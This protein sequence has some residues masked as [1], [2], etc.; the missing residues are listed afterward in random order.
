MKSVTLEAFPRSV[1]KRNAVKKLRNGGRIPGV[2]YGRGLG[3][4]DVEIDTNA[5]E[6]LVK[7][8]TSEALLVDLNCD[9]KKNLALIQEAQQH[10]LSG[11]FLHIDL[12]L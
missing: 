10:P 9:G 4:L 3:S 12:H 8:A 7:K 2:L 11:Q 5:F 6:I 1:K